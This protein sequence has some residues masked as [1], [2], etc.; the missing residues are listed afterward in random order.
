MRLRQS[1]RILLAAGTFLLLGSCGGGTPPKLEPP[2]PAPPRPA[3]DF[4]LSV[5]D[6]SIVALQ[7]SG[8]ETFT[9]SVIPRNEFT[10]SVNVSFV[11]LP[12]WIS[13]SVT[14]PVVIASGETTEMTFRTDAS[15]PL[16]S[17]TITLRGVSGDISHD[18]LFTLQVSPLELSVSTDT[19][20]ADLGSNSGT[21]LLS[22]VPIGTLEFPIE[23]TLADPPTGVFV[24][25]PAGFTLEIGGTT[26]LIYSTLATAPPGDS[27]VTLQGT[28]ESAV[29]TATM[30]LTVVDTGG[31]NLRADPNIFTLRPGEDATATISIDDPN[32]TLPGDDVVNFTVKT[33]PLG[34]ETTQSLG[35]VFVGT[36]ET[37]EVEATPIAQP[38]TDLFIH[39]EGRSRETDRIV[40]AAIVLT[41]DVPF[42][43]GSSLSRSTFV[44][45]DEDPSD[46]HYDPTRN[47]IY[48]AVHDLNKI[49]VYESTS[50]EFVTRISVP[51]PVS[52]DVTTD[53]TSVL[54]GTATPFIY[55]IDPIR[56]EVVDRVKLPHFGTSSSRR[57]PERLA[58]TS[59]GEVLISAQVENSSGADLVLWNPATN[60]FEYPV[61]PESV[62]TKLLAASADDRWVLVAELNNL[63]LYDAETKSIVA[64]AS[65][66]FDLGI[67][68]AGDIASHPGGTMFAVT[69]RDEVVVLDPQLQEIARLNLTLAEGVVFSPDGGF[70]YVGSNDF[71][72][73]ITVYETETFSIV[74]LVPYT[75]PG[76]RSTPITDGD[77]TGMLFARAGKGVMF[78]DASSP[79]SLTIDSNRIA[80]LTPLMGALGSTAPVTIRGVFKD[81]VD[82]VYFGA[83]PGSPDAT[84]ATSVVK[85]SDNELSVRPPASTAPGPVNV[86]VTT[87][88]GWVEVGED[89]YTYGPHILQ[90]LPSVGTPQGGTEVV[91]YGYGLRAVTGE[92]GVTVGG[93]PATVLEPGGVGGLQNLP[94][95]VQ[96]VRIETPAG[97]SGPAD[98]IV[99]NSAGSTTLPDG[100]HYL[101]SAETYS[102][103]GLLS[104]I[105]HDPTRNVLFVTNTAMNQVLV[106]DLELKTFLTPLATG[107][108]PMGVALT[109]DGS[110]MITANSGDGTISLIDPDGVVPSTNVSVLTASEAGGSCVPEPLEV[111]PTSLNTTF[112]TS[113]GSGCGGW[114]RE[115]DL[116][117][118]DVT[119]RTSPD[120]NSD[121]IWLAGSGDGTRVA[122]KSQSGV[123]LWSA[124]TDTFLEERHGA[125]EVSI[126]EDGDMVGVGASLRDD[127]LNLTSR[128]QDIR[129]MNLAVDNNNNFPQGKL[130]PS[131]SLVYLPHQ[132]GV[133]IF[134]SHRGRLLRSV[135]FPEPLVLTL[136][137]IELDEH[138]KRIFAITES[139]LTVVELDSVPLSIGTVSPGQGLP[140]GGTPVTIRGS[141]FKAGAMVKFGDAEVLT[142]FVDENTL[143]VISPSMPAGAVRIT[144][145]NPD[146]EEYYLDAG[147]RFTN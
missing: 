102:A 141:G 7:G 110:T 12:T 27:T 29:G 39:I 41:V 36:T 112:F 136:D 130:H 106:F 49:D 108:G 16:G 111:A 144:I 55:V 91:L 45:T 84:P 137:G 32:G 128:A 83:A 115:M 64:S 30:T 119:V 122:A 67:A 68:H 20:S 105:A 6:G 100:F 145:T 1:L 9:V 38:V 59:T 57:F 129:Y 133:D 132:T 74:G 142:T 31:F 109:P 2:P 43:S 71:V 73:Y 97:L 56:L 131:G 123:V 139:G 120:N 14:I 17:T 33:R 47:Q 53:G 11:D 10:G 82:Q 89:A 77:S 140:V 18:R 21:F 58:A 13:P 8:S 98:I 50:A 3:A 96:A 135:A 63:A 146:G 52:V 117:T 51:N 75:R 138:G 61:Y 22:I 24:P 121:F 80:G 66:S 28:H 5:S 114:L 15:A 72:P 86:T 40:N 94:F 85:L 26:G 81:E 44:R 90:V 101:K 65:P 37:L 103:A 126:S 93:S 107:V 124:D 99:T 79:G 62:Q 70:L 147:Y 42:G 34:I 54:V 143:E 92:P 69:G 118:F 87:Q 113:L 60:L 127:D 35:G 95:P 76:D 104:Q 134:D 88:G 48:V 4:S 78:V 19:V 25:I 125:R 116:D 46:I 23:V